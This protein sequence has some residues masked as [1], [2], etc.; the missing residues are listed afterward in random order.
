MANFKFAEARGHY[1]QP[2][3]SKKGKKT[4]PRPAIGGPKWQ[5]MALFIKVFLTII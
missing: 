4:N 3:V 2:R 5:E 1:N